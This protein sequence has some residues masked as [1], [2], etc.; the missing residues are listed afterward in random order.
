MDI[1]SEVKLPIDSAAPKDAIQDMHDSES[2][3][4]DR[5]TDGSELNMLRGTTSPVSLTLPESSNLLPAVST[6]I[7]PVATPQLPDSD[8]QLK[9]LW[10]RIKVKPHLKRRG[11]PKHSSKLW[12]S[13]K[14]ERLHSQIRKTNTHHKANLR[15]GRGK[16][17]ILKMMHHRVPSKLFKSD[18]MAEG[19]SKVSDKKF[20][21]RVLLPIEPDCDA[22][23]K[24][25]MTHQKL[26]KLVTAMMKS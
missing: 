23:E 13:K 21:F 16:M 8:S 11:R 1:D 15:K 12:P 3:P 6:H 2:F 5:D 14:R 24:K 7:P 18:T 25:E 10:E 19:C 26:W 4:S 22:K 9:L 20:T 17:I